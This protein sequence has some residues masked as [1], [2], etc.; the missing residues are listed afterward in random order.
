MNSALNVGFSVINDVVDVVSREAIVR[1]QF[2]RVDGRT[3]PNVIA[4]V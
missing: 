4:Y 3:L 2:V 1:E